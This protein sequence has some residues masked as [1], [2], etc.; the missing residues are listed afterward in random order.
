M[1]RLPVPQAFEEYLKTVSSPPPVQQAG[2]SAPLASTPRTS[3]PLAKSAWSVAVWAVCHALESSRA[4]RIAVL[5]LVVLTTFVAATYALWY[6]AHA[7]A[8]AQSLD[9]VLEDASTK[10]AESLPGLLDAGVEVGVGAAGASLLSSRLIE[11]ITHNVGLVVVGLLLGL[12]V[13]RRRQAPQPVVEVEAIDVA[14]APNLLAPTSAP[15]TSPHR[16]GACSIAGN[17]RKENQDRVYVGHLAGADLCIVADGMGGLP[18]GGTAAD[19]ATN[20]ARERLEVELPEL[21]PAGPDAIRALLVGVVWQAATKLAEAVVV[22]GWSRENPGL[23][24]TLIVVVATRNY[25]LLAFVGDGGV[26]VLREGGEVVSLL[27]PHKDM[28]EPNVLHASLGP[29]IEGRPAWAVMERRPGDVLV[30]A[31][32]GIADVFDAALAARV[33][34]E[35]DRTEGNAAQTAWEIVREMAFAQ[36]EAGQFCVT[37]NLTCAVIAG[38]DRS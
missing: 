15:F 9:G 30:V 31:T 2:V 27:D 18:R 22:H 32:D 34:A 8:H 3:S 25:Y 23:R 4:W 28:A 21:L 37:D 20:Y 6:F 11:V 36:D 24:T 17:T 26:F 7:T 19:I 1:P 14:A 12:V 33:R 5:G 10:A 35:L 38:E 16:L 13:R 29:S